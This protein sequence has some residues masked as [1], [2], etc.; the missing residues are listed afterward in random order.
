MPGIPEAGKAVP[1]NQIQLSIEKVL[2][3]KV[4]PLTAALPVYNG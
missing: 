4:V 3:D 1:P 2:G